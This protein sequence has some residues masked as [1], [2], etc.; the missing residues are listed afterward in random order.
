VIETNQGRHADAE[1]RFV[2]A[3]EIRRRALGERDPRVGAALDALGGAMLAQGRLDDAR[4]TL[5]EA[6][7]ILLEHHEPGDDAILQNVNKRVV[8]MTQSG[9]N[10]SAIE[11]LRPHAEAVASRTDPT[12]AVAVTLNTMAILSSRAGDHD[13]AQ[14][15]Y[16]RN[17]DVCRILYGPTHA[18]T[19]KARANAAVAKDRAGLKAEAEADYRTI[20]AVRAG[21]LGEDHPDTISSRLNLAVLLIRVDRAE[22]AIPIL[23]RAIDD[24]TRVLGA[25]NPETAIARGA[26][27][28]SILRLGDPARQAQAEEMLNRALEDLER[29][30]G[31]ESA[32]RSGPA[33]RS[34]N[35]ATRRSPSTPGLPKAD[36]AHGVAPRLPPLG[37]GELTCASKICPALIPPSLAGK[38]RFSSSLTPLG[39]RAPNALESRSFCHTPPLATTVSAPPASRAAVTFDERA[40]ASSS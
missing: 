40:P 31:P 21:A 24:Y 35:S 15:W 19:L 33:G 28:E 30:L 17:I 39:S 4:E 22:E 9:D 13:E 7:A 25:G 10:A 6:S 34:K 1:P 5:D 23:R 14:R 18:H 32:P 27:G 37:D 26:L 8:P 38:A 12:P 29:T 3:I 11:I 2:R 20:L 36:Q 16:A